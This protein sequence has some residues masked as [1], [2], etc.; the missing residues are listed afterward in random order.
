MRVLDVGSGSKEIARKHFPEAEVI[1]SLDIDPA[2][3]PDVLAD[4][5]LPL[6]A[7]Y[8][9][10][11]DVVHLSHVLEHINWAQVIGT[12]RNLRELLKPGGELHIY[13]P[14][15]E[16][17]A[18]EILKP[19]AS[20]VLMSHLYG[21]QSSPWQ[22]HRSGYTLPM[23][24]QLM[25]LVG[26]TVIQAGQSKLGIRWAQGE[27]VENYTSLQNVVVARRPLGAVETVEPVLAL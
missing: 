20:N 17:A 8:W 26:L 2:T 13:V 10:Q 16:W 7:D 18:M 21:S 9:A 19:K 25:A 24:R 4:I 23:L 1:I 15:L 27:E 14:A 12:L 3:E 6:P 22:Y 11:F 5:T